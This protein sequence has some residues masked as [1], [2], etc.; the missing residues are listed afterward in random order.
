LDLERVEIH[1]TLFIFTMSFAQGATGTQFL[2]DY[3]GN[4]REG[5]KALLGRKA[6]H[7]RR[8]FLAIFFLRTY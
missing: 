3:K 1:K 4:K 7:L 2:R 5:N 8:R 6:R